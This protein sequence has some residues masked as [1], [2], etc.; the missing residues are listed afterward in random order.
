MSV[1]ICIL[2]HPSNQD[3]SHKQSSDG[4]EGQRQPGHTRQTGRLVAQVGVAACLSH[5]VDGGV[6]AAGGEIHVFGLVA[7]SLY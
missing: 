4:G 7:L 1:C 3:V 6:A 5:R 2:C